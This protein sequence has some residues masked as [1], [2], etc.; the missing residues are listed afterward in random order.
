MDVDMSESAPLL[1]LRWLAAKQILEELFWY[2]YGENNVLSLRILEVV[3]IAW[4]L[5]RQ[6]RS[7]RW[8][9]EANYAAAASARTIWLRKFMGSK[10]SVDRST[11]QSLQ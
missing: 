4:S 11:R 5:L 7:R 6:T 1:T 2:F 3:S 10:C 9:T 8:R